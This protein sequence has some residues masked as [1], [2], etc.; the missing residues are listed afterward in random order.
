M[1]PVH[2]NVSKR[3]FSEMSARKPAVS[4]SRALPRLQM[5]SFARNLSRRTLSSHMPFFFSVSVC[6]LGKNKHDDFQP[7]EDMYITYAHVNTVRHKRI[8]HISISRVS[9][10]CFAPVS[11][12]RR[13]QCRKVMSCPHYPL[14]FCLQWLCTTMN[15]GPDTLGCIYPGMM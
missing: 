13:F 3:H 7:Q 14:L 4:F 10:R 12:L 11:C 2:V 1:Y 5:P 6:L 9:M 8:P 15:L